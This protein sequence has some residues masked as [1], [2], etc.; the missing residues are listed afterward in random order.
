MTEQQRWDELLKVAEAW[1][2]FDHRHE[3]DTSEEEDDFLAPDVTK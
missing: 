2:A 1:A 3:M